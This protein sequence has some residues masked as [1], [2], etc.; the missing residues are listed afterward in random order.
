MLCGSCLSTSCGALGGIAPC[1]M[2]KGA[3]AALVV[4]FADRGFSAKV[5]QGPPV[6]DVRGLFFFGFGGC[7][8]RFPGMVA[9]KP[10]GDSRLRAGQKQF[11][12]T[13]RIIRGR[14]PI[15]ESLGRL[16]DFV[17]LCRYGI[18]NNFPVVVRPSKS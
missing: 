4:R 10:V 16:S 9:G 13:Q 12:S 2:M 15:L 6:D 17:A 3:R 8:F 11:R 7:A 14:N 18:S 1:R 5:R